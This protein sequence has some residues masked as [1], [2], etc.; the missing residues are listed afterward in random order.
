METFLEETMELW[1]VARPQKSAAVPITS[2]LYLVKYGGR[3]WS[4]CCDICLKFLP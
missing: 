1:D 2:C 4:W 3:T